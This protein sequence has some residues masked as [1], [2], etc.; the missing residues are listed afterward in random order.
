MTRA[1]SHLRAARGGFTLLELLVAVTILVIAM[2]VIWSTFS[3]GVTAWQ[4]GNQLLDDLR[5]ADFVAEQLVSAL[6]STAFFP[7][8]PERYGFRLKTGA[9]GYPADRISWVTSSSAFIPPE[10]PWRHGLHRIVFSIENNDRGEPSVAIRA[11]SHL[12]DPEE[13]DEMDVEPWYVSSDVKGFRCRFYDFEEETWSSDWEDTNSIPSLLE[14]T[15][16]MEPLE[17]YGPPVTL[18]RLV[19]IPVAP[20]VTNAVKPEQNEA[21][22]QEK[23]PG[24]QRKQNEQR[25]VQPTREGQPRQLRLEA[26]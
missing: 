7:N 1:A 26:K 11:L 25:Q 13:Q 22:S 15:L 5:H 17:K 10:S 18:Q 4:R 8:T 20:A 21:G 19:V 6:R 24:D 12:A 16:Y 14:I 23:A 9:L 3:A 2:T